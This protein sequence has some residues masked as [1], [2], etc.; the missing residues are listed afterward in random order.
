[1]P[2]IQRV[3]WAGN[4][5][6]VKKYFST[7]YGK[8]NQQRGIREKPTPEEQMRVN[9]DHAEEKLR[10][11]ISTNFKETDIHLVVTYFKD[12]R[13]DIETALKQ[14]QNMLRR[15][16]RVYEK[17][18][19]EFKYIAVTEYK[20]KAIHHHLIINQ[21]D[22]ALLQKKWP[23]GKLRPTYLDN[24]YAKLAAYLIKET[25]KSFR[26]ED[27]PIT[28]RWSAS[29][30]LKKPKIKKQI[31]KANKWNDIPKPI[32]GY[33]IDTDSIYNGQHKFTGHPYQ[34]YVMKRIE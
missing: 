28:K 31:I 23:Y 24:D 5:V 25:S 14:R 27:C 32:K 16:A 34:T 21:I 17:Q 12:I 4:T 20:N 33:Y 6:E 8:K 19:L 13:P 11:L 1:M 22:V 3:V 7:Q 2:Y 26:D 10:W 15:F 18:G 30:N 29:R 9:E